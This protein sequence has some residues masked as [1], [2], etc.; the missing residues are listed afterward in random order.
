MGCSRSF[1]HL[2]CRSQAWSKTMRFPERWRI[3]RGR[4]GRNPLWLQICSFSCRFGEILSKIIVWFPHLCSWRP[5]SRKSWIRHCW[6]MKMSKQQFP[7]GPLVVSLSQSFSVSVNTK[8]RIL[9]TNKKNT[10]NWHILTQGPNLL[11]RIPANDILTTTIPWAT[12][13]MSLDRNKCSS[14]N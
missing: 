5:S 14:L 7:I 3:Q 6:C 1:C 8:Q 12:L 11:Q 13:K 9:S 10:C 4:Q 2:H